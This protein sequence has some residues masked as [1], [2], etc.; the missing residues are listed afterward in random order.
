[1]PHVR[2]RPNGTGRKGALGGF[3]LDF[4][5]IRVELFRACLE[6]MRHLDREHSAVQ[7][8]VIGRLSNVMAAHDARTVSR[9]ADQL[10]NGME[11]VD[12][13]PRQIVNA[14]ERRQGWHL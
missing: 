12:V 6:L 13:V 8:S 14:L 2:I 7:Q 4:E 3:E 1:M 5:A 11:E 9:L 10:P